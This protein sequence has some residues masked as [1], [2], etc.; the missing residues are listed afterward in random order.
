MVGWEREK[1][2]FPLSG[3]WAWPTLPRT[4]TIHGKASGHAEQRRL[5]RRDW[6]LTTGARPGDKGMAAI[7]F[8]DGCD[9]SS[10][11]PQTGEWCRVCRIV[12]AGPQATLE[13]RGSSLGGG[14]TRPGQGFVS[15]KKGSQKGPADHGPDLCRQVSPSTALLRCR[16]CAARGQTGQAQAVSTESMFSETAAQESPLPQLKW[17]NARVNCR[18]GL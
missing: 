18:A 14:D 6:A 13:R 11:M 15:A 5:D 8:C 2:A 17:R 16:C 12:M 7:G 3:P 4:G 9:L 1:E 10:G